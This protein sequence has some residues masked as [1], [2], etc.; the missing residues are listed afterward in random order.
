M[1]Y[2]PPKRTTKREKK[3][4]SNGVDSKVTS[5][6]VIIGNLLKRKIVREASLII[7]LLDAKCKE[8]KIICH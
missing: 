4:N 8:W 7:I 5:D 1:A 3:Q 2:F 6:H